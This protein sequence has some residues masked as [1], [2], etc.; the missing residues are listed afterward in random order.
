MAGI[1]S[2]PEEQKHVFHDLQP[3]PA[4][5]FG[6]IIVLALAAILLTTGSAAAVYFW[7]QQEVTQLRTQNSD[8]QQQVKSIPLP[9]TEK[10]E[11]EPVKL[12]IFEKTGIPFSFSYPEQW[13]L[14]LDHFFDKAT[15]LDSYQNY[16]LVLYVPGSRHEETG[17]GGIATVRGAKIGVYASKTQYKTMAELAATKGFRAMTKDESSTT[18]GGLP[19]LRYY[20]AWEGPNLLTTSV[21]KDG[22]QYTIQ[23]DV[24]GESK[25]EELTAPVFKDYEALVK[26]F[27]FK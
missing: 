4:K 14:T 25:G 7:Q 19:A 15:K 22:W 12:T 23:M 2:M 27:T 6:K 5:R 18:M 26:S 11:E 21:I 8:L 3:K 17:I 10:K 24:E 16:T 1:F 20:T 9:V 13:T